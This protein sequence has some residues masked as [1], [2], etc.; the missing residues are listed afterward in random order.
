MAR[1][2]KS[3][4][5]A[6]VCTPHT[7][8]DLSIHYLLPWKFMLITTKFSKLVSFQLWTPNF[9]GFSQLNSYTVILSDIYKWSFAT[10]KK[11][12]ITI[13]IKGLAKSK[14]KLK[15]KKKI[16]LVTKWRHY[17]PLPL[18]LSVGEYREDGLPRPLTPSLLLPFTNCRFTGIKFL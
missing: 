13:I 8:C 3:S 16:L 15:E 1:T 6:A 17:S 11:R 18:Y 5:W 2:C 12:L 14:Q 7:N 9:Q 4:L 10:L